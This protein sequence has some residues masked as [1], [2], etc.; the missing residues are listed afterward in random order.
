MTPAR[1]K[2]AIEPRIRRRRQVE[3]ERENE[4]DDERDEVDLDMVSLH[5]I[6]RGERRGLLAAS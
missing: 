4:L 5:C 6:S 2:A 3:V 1:V